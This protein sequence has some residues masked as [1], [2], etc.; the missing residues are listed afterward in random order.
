MSGGM[1]LFHFFTVV[2]L[3]LVT[4]GFGAFLVSYAGF[5]GVLLTWIP[6]SVLVAFVVSWIRNY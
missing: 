6:A 5:F 3:L 4:L 1:C 2:F